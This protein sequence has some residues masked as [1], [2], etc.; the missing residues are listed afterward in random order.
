M[1]CFLLS[2]LNS[3]LFF[4]LIL[5]RRRINGMVGMR[6]SKL[7]RAVNAFELGKGLPRTGPHR[8]SGLLETALIY[9]Y[10]L[11]THVGYSRMGYLYIWVIYTGVAFFFF[12]HGTWMLGSPWATMINKVQS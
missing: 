10:G 9:I 11:F 4:Y 3:T 7:C 12:N 5:T 1:K 6:A 8:L 2:S